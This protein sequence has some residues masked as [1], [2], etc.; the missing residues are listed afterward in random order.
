[1]WIRPGI[2]FFV[3]DIYQQINFFQCYQESN[4][5]ICVVFFRTLLT[6]PRSHIWLVKKYKGI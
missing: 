4:Y 5:E 2:K 1:M 6:P 3:T